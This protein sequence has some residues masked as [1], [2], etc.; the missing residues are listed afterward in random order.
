MDV[1]KPLLT[2]NQVYHKIKKGQPIEDFIIEERINFSSIAIKHQYLTFSSIFRN[3]IGIWR[4]TAIKNPVIFRNC[5]ISV[6][7]ALDVAFLKLIVFEKCIIRVFDLTSCYAK[8]G[9][10]M[11]DCEFIDDIGLFRW[12]GHNPRNKP[13]KITNCV[14]HGFVDTEDAFFNGP[15]EISNCRFLK[16]SNFLANKGQPNGTFFALNP[17]I[18]KNEGVLD[19]IR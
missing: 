13:I 4:E 6:L 16:G 17:I 15:V 10:I 11:N 7:F 3:K 9:M 1:V 19:L 8:G 2:A 18:K 14:F 5:R 12:G